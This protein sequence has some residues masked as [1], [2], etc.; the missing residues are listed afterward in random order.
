VENRKGYK[1][2]RENWNENAILGENTYGRILLAWIIGKYNV[3]LTDFNCPRIAFCSE[4]L[5]TRQ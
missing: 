3:L 1:I 2:F 4:L 5:W